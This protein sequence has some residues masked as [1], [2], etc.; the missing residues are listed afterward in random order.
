MSMMINGCTKVTESTV[1]HLI[2]IIGAHANAV[3]PDVTKAYD[4][5]MNVCLNEGVVDIIV[6][7]G[8]PAIV[9]SIDL[10][11]QV[12]GL[13]SSKKKS[14]AEAQCSQIL[15]YASSLTARVSEVDILKSLI[16]AGDQLADQPN[17]KIIVL[18]S[19]LQTK[20]PL[21]F[22]TMLLEGGSSDS[23]INSLKSENYIP[24]LQ[25]IDVDIY[26][27]GDVAEPQQTLTQ[28]NIQVL[29]QIWEKILAESGATFKI[30]KEHMQNNNNDEKQNLPSVTPVP[31]SE[32]KDIQT[33]DN[34]NYISLDETVISFEPDAADIKDEVSAQKNIDS[35]MNVISNKDMSI[36][37]VGCTAKQGNLDSCIHLSTLRAE[38]IKNMLVNAGMSSSRIE[39]I[40]TGYDSVFYEPDN[41]ESGHLIENI[42]KQN[43]KVVII[44]R[45]SDIANELI[46][47]WHK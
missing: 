25:D 44:D 2:L 24:S 30:N 32:V 10:P 16:L 43:R 28:K 15:E 7:D 3:K 14:I 8:N 27:L 1:E 20:S 11:S 18:D 17:S 5:V 38:K 4:D 46:K 21:N 22:A 33:L 37:L 34:S 40:G 19:C 12:R 35:I 23:V 31:I 36:L 39:V 9:R 41:D 42:A 6:S 13:S 26:G 47:K 45:S 29:Q